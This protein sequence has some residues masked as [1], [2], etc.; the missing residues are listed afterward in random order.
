M[1]IVLLSELKGHTLRG[2][3]VKRRNLVCLVKTKEIVQWILHLTRISEPCLDRHS[4]DKIV[5]CIDNFIRR[6]LISRK[7]NVIAQFSVK[8]EKYSNIL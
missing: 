1:G 6:N 7:R 5:N 2:A 4:I 3:K 8:H